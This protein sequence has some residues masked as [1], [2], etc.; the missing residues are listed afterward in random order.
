MTIIKPNSVV[1]FQGDSITDCGRNR[2]DLHSLGS[3][4]PLIAAGLFSALYPKYNVRFINKGIGGNRVKDLAA[5]WHQDCLDL[6]P[7]FVSVMIGINDVWRRYDANDV[8]SV[9]SFEKSLYQILKLTKDNLA[10]DILLFEPYVL[11]TPP[12]RYSW[13]EDLDP[14]RQAVRRLAQRFDAIF[15][16]MDEIFQAAVIEN[17]AE[18]WCPDG[19]HP[20]PAGHGLIAKAWL[21]AVEST[22][23]P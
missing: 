7:D 18:F 20:S 14:K 3:G 10:A 19:V 15:I 4:Y 23:F 2:K 13:R 1:L 9:S 8:T 12:D 5:R 21:Q 16:P 6:Q 17:T 22:T 11:H